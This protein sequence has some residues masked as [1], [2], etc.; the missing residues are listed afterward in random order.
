[1]L[2]VWDGSFYISRA[3]AMVQAN[4]QSTLVGNKEVAASLLALNM[5]SKDFKEFH[6]LHSCFVFDHPGVNF[7]HSIDE[8]YKCNH[9][10]DEQATFKQYQTRLTAHLLALAGFNVVQR[11]GVEADD[12]IASIAFSTDQQVTIFTGDKDLQQLVTNKVST[13]DTRQKPAWRGTPE[14]V[15]QRYGVPPNRIAHLLALMGDA[16]DGVSGVSGVGQKK[17]IKL[18]KEYGSIK[19]IIK[20]G[21][22][23]LEQEEQLRTSYKLVKLEN[24]CRVKLDYYSY[25]P[26]IEPISVEQLTSFYKEAKQPLPHLFKSVVSVSTLNQGKSLFDEDVPTKVT[27]VPMDDWPSLLDAL[28]QGNINYDSLWESVK[29]PPTQNSLFYDECQEEVCLQS[30]SS[31]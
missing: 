28:E 30:V 17:A 14:T 15:E 19:G 16:N 3:L 29:R 8:S 6:P 4:K 2:A 11:Q 7:R 31:A 26:V 25:V 23:S 22:L 27:A 21:V 10:A 9:A 20:A 13:V 12:I 5:F 18:L 24:N 1:M